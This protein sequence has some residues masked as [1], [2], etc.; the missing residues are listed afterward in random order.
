MYTKKC[1][2][3]QFRVILDTKNYA[4]WATKLQFG[5]KRDKE[6]D[7]Y[8]VITIFKRNLKYIY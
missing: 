8:A 3:E 6:T 5:H 2:L 4:W 1:I 7:T